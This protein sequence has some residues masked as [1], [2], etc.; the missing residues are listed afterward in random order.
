[1]PFL[2][3]RHLRRLVFYGWLQGPLDANAFAGITYQ[4]PQHPEKHAEQE[5]DPL[6]G[7]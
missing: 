4:S 6:L 7:S 3:L 2:R 5:S 1:M